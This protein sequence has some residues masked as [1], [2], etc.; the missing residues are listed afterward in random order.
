[1]AK[2]QSE[3]NNI[4]DKIFI[5]IIIPVYNDQYALDETLKSI[6]AQTLSSAN[7]EII[8]IDNN[9]TP[10][11]KTCANIP[12]PHKIYSYAKPGSYAARNYGVKKSKGDILVFIDS[13]C[14][15][16]PQWL[17]A[18]INAL[19]KN[20][21]SVIGG[22]VLF[23]KSPN[24]TIIE[25]YQYITGCSRLEDI[26]Y[27]GFTGAG[28]MFTTADTFKT[29]GP[30]NET[31]YSGGDREWCWR[32][33]QKGVNIRFCPDAITYTKARRTL[34]K[35]LI[36]ARRIAGGRK[37]LRGFNSLSSDNKQQIT[38]HRGPFQAVK[39]IFSQKQ[40]SCFVRIKILFVAT[41]IKAVAFAEMLI[42][43]L[44][45]NAERR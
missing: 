34:R 23:E 33:Q 3:T 15:P 39:F 45:A 36:Q 26:L 32:A 25:Q 12:L 17:E 11:I 7:F 4:T 37:Q 31:L 42:L 24:P 8:V 28:N 10:P 2:F 35:A 14:H 16:V 27:K 9:S 1:M 21:N 19:L 41:L 40:L 29:V 38:P 18:G 6:C 30:F 20:E 44:G 13:D 43:S 22:E 5:S